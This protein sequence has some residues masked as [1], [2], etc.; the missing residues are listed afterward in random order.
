MG[1]VRMVI[2]RP[3]HEPSPETTPSGMGWGFEKRRKM[4]DGLGFTA[5]VGIKWGAH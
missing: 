5:N 4:A 1:V 3:V 2:A